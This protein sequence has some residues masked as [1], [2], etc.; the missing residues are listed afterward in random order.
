MACSWGPSA[1]ITPF[2]TDHRYSS[3]QQERSYLLS[4]LATEESGAEHIALTLKTTRAKLQIA[5]AQEDSAAVARNLRK[6]MAAMTR[7]LKKCHRNEQAM[8][9]NLAAVT[10]R[11][12]ILEQNQWRKA[13]LD[14]SERMQQA[15][16][17]AMVLGLQGMTLE[18]PMFPAY[19]YP[20][21]QCP[22]TSYTVSHLGGAIP[23]VPATP[24]LLPQQMMSSIESAWNTPLF[25]PYH[26]QFLMP[27]GMG[28]PFS[29]PQPIMNATRQNMDMNMN[30]QSPR[31]AHAESNEPM[32]QSRRMSLPDP[33]RRSS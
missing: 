33:P 13:Q 14:H 1:P 30:L 27:L 25:T 24:F 10:A 28:T 32:K 21:T 19:G 8:A 4:A 5:E 31:H 15:P 23:S 6:T 16:I 29:T 26:E 18:S 17:Y 9:N 12:Q 22:P 11:M 2:V 3:L 20:C 7:K